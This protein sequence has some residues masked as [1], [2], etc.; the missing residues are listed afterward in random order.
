M[1]LRVPCTPAFRLP[2]VHAR[3]CAFRSGFEMGLQAQF[4]LAA[5]MRVL[6]QPYTSTCHRSL[7][8]FVG[9]GRRKVPDL[10]L[11]FGGFLV[12]WGR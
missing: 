5:F 8:W 7:S 1:D 11:V 4:L 9:L 6:C 12:L 10:G 2:G 3:A